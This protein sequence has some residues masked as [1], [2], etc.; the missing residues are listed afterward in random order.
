MTIQNLKSK[1]Q[2]R[3]DLLALTLDDLALLANR[4]L[5]KR[6]Q[7]EIEAGEL[8][9]ELDEDA[10]G[11]V[12][13]RWSDG[14]KCVLPGEKPASAGRCSCPAT[15]ICRHILRSVLAY[16]RHAAQGRD[17]GAPRIERHTPWNPGD[18]TDDDLARHVARGSLAWARRAF[19]EGQVIELV[20]AA[21]PSAIMHTQACTVRFLA[22]GDVRYTHCD[23]AEPAPCRH[24]PL[25]VWAFRKLDESHTSG[26]VETAALPVAAPVSLLD[27]IEGTLRELVSLGISGAPQALIERLRR[28]EQRCRTEGLIWPADI[29]ADLTQQHVAYSAHDARFDPAQLT[30]LIGELCVR[31]DAIRANTGAIPQL[32]V[33]GAASDVET[34]IGAAR[35][36][37]LGC[38]VRVH[39]GGIT[40][41]AYMQDADTGSLLVVR[42]DV[43]DPPPD[44]ATPPAP[45]WRLAQTPVSQGIGLAAFGGGQALIKGGRRK[46]NAQLVPGRARMALNPQNYAWESLRAPLLVED[47][48]EL[49]ARIAAQPPAALRPRRLTDGLYVCPVAG[50][51][52]ATFSPIEQIVRA[53]LR[54]ASGAEAILRHPYTSRGQAGVEVLLAALHSRLDDL[55]FIAGHVQLT[56]H[57]PQI[58]PTALVFQEGTGRR[59]IQPWIDNDAKSAGDTMSADHHVAGAD[60]LVAYWSQ[61][62]DVLSDLLVVGMGRADERTAR[63]WRE[64]ARFGAALG[65]TRLLQPPAQLA[66]ELERKLSTLDWMSEQALE[67]ALELACMLQLVWGGIRQDG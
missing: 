22:P 31:I 15:S 46:P 7:Q 14:I 11:S 23:C 3:H 58:A 19:D 37:G 65:F 54:D 56:A 32:F 26:I 52:N 61:V 38:D 49:T 39:R 5:A 59:A 41:A 13:V 34:T 20:R 51:E 10:Q 9:Y 24:A 16:Q 18:I 57:G 63:R 53:T 6:A 42:R 27:E 21:K 67:S 1:I 28:Q 60:P 30:A 45:F 48:T 17:E 44:D 66:A 4:G 40:L 36:I 62:G 12:T 8:T 47:F 55:R 50:A 25:A 29:L 64:L 35:L 33:R 2:N 43:A